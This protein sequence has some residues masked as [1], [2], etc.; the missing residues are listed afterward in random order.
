MHSSYF[1]YALQSTF[2]AFLWLLTYN[3]CPFF[4]LLDKRVS[5]YPHYKLQR[6]A[7]DSGKMY[8]DLYS[9]TLC[10]AIDIKTILLS[11]NNKVRPF[12]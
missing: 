5:I 11:A 3:I 1:F 9:S 6:Y 12:A 8:T 7:E 4:R 2:K 10:Y